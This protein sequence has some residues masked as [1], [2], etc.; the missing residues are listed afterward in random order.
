MVSTADTSKKKIVM[1]RL[2]RQMAAEVRSIAQ[3]ENET[4]AVIL[5][6]LLRRGLESEQAGSGRA[7]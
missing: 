6:R 7:A 5:R 2:P 4:D 1:L 3:R